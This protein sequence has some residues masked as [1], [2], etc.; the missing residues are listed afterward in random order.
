MRLLALILLWLG[1]VGFGLMTLCSGVFLPMA[2][3]IA[4]P[5]GLLSGLFVWACL[6]GLRRHR[7]PPEPFPSP[8]ASPAQPTADD[9]DRA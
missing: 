3:W 4:L 8:P 9:T 5:F 7:R 1:V 2:P 6:L